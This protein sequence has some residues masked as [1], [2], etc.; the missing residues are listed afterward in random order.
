MDI[1]VSNNAIETAPKAVDA[2][3]ARADLPA[4]VSASNAL[5]QIA[6]PPTGSANSAGQL[7][8]ALQSINETLRAL[9]QNVEFSIDDSSDHRIV[10]RIVD[11]QTQEIIRQIP[12]EEALQIAKGLDRVQGLLIH[13]KA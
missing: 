3:S 2:G 12:S 13:Q 6:V 4:I 7:N 10:V 1:R 8:E 11:Q 5:Q 9:S